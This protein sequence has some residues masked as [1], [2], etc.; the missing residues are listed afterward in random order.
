MRFR[1]A[2]GDDWEISTQDFVRDFLASTWPELL[3]DGDDPELGTVVGRY[4]KST[5]ESE[6][7]IFDLN[8][9]EAWASAILEIAG[10]LGRPSVEGHYGKA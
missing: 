8:T 7:D 9:A 10:E 6:V 4:V 1:A 2:N 3:V 5:L